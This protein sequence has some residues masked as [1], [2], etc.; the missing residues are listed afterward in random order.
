MAAKNIADDSLYTLRV[1]N[2]IKMAVSRTVSKIN[3]FYAETQYGHQ[4]WR[5]SYF[6]QKVADNSTHT[7]W[8]KIFVKLALSHTIC[9]INRFL[10][11][12]SLENS[13]N[14]YYSLSY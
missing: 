14:S 6:W 12:P 11:F 3:A 8:V 13:E 2:F 5:E 4:K 1:K 7:L 9:K 10:H